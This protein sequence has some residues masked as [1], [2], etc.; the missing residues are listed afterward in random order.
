MSDE[1]EDVSDLESIGSSYD[2][3][4]CPISNALP[5]T[6]DTK[7]YTCQYCKT[8]CKAL[9]KFDCTHSYCIDCLDLENGCT[10]CDLQT[11]EQVALDKYFFKTDFGISCPT[12][13]V[14]D[15]EYLQQNNKP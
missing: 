13:D 2:D 6:D 10:I 9:Y 4:P 15:L 14:Q 3:S 12:T 8:N 5:P 7:P 11:L 1:Y